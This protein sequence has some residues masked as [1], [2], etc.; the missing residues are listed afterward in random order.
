MI[1]ESYHAEKEALFSPGALLGERKNICAAAIAMFSGEIYHAVLGKY[2]HRVVSQIDTV[3]GHIPLYLLDVNDK[4]VIFYLSPIGSCLAG[5]II[6]EAQWQ[7]GFQ[8]LIVFGSAGALD[9]E[10]TNGKYVI[11]TQAYRDEGL[12]YHYAPPVDYI[13]VKNSDKLA[14]IFWELRLPFVQGRVWTT[15]AIYRETK[16]AVAKRKKD[17]CIAVEME[18]AGMQAVCDF[19]GIELYD[20]LVTDDVLDGEEYDPDGL[21]EANHSLGKFYVALKILEK[22]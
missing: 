9:S 8:K 3:N 10:A 17:G 22:I 1:T 4:N 6:I 18:L 15:D 2:A 13:D 14:R 5:N 7:T 19:H 16:T 12:S 21:D 11:P 20:F